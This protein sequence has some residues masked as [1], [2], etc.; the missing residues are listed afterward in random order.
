MGPGRPNSPWTASA[1]HV[2][3]QIISTPAADY[4]ITLGGTLDSFNTASYTTTDNVKTMMESPWF[5]PDRFLILANVGTVDVLCPRVV[6]NGRRNWHSADDLLDSIIWPGMSDRAK[7]F[8]LFRFFSR[9]DVQAH[10]NNLRVDDVMPDLNAA[11]G[12]N[13]FRERADPIKAVNSYY[14]S[15]C[16]LSAA[17]LVIMARHAGLNARLLAAAPLVGPF[18]KHGGAEIEYEGAYHYFD[19]EAR[20]FFLDRDNEKVASYEEIHRDPALVL[21]THAHGFAAQECKGAFIMLYREHFPPYEVPVE[22]WV[23][24][25]DLRLRPGEEL[26]YR[27][28]NSGK[29]RYG[30]NP[31][32]TPGPPY[33]LANGLLRFCPNLRNSGYR[34]G[35]VHEVNTMISEPD[36]NVALLRPLISNHPASVTWKIESPY[37]IVGGRVFGKFVMEAEGGCSVSV[38]IGDSWRQ[39]WKK[40]GAGVFHVEAD[41][42]SV[43]NALTS[44]AIYYYYVRFD[45]GTTGQPSAVGL[46][47]VRL[48]SDLQMSQT[49]LPALSVGRN[50]VSVRMRSPGRPVDGLRLRVSHGWV[51]CAGAA[52]PAAPLHAVL[53][54][55][56]GSVRAANLTELVWADDEVDDIAD[57]HVLVSS[58]PD[59]LLPVSPNFDRFA[60]SAVPRWKVARSF[61]RPGL[62]YYWKVRARNVEGV[63]SQWSPTWTFT[64]V[65]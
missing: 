52:P 41:I 25:M 2:F 49:S 5:Q 29:Y 48:E 54:E 28:D 53:P 30:S 39:V 1:T 35:I 59:F 56:G 9:F 44:P 23:H 16:I 47:S 11:P 43:L 51:E 46:D 61:L 20:T 27:W 24:H 18:D 10:N 32:N 65:G 60:F 4:Q 17:N 19:P 38:S 63:W 37:P 62:R 58:R 55:D 15:G 40:E 6:I 42:D 7:A 34:G 50:N 8:A 33:R 45:F 64:V 3:E 36:T 14:P 22:Q 26:V 13:S 31:R 57:H 12:S 21:R